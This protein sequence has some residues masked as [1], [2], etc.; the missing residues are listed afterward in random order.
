[1]SLLLLLSGSPND[2]ITEP[3]SP[4]T[5]AGGASSVTSFTVTSPGTVLTDDVVLVMVA[6]RQDRTIT[7]PSGWSVVSHS[8]GSGSSGLNLYAFW[9]R[10]NPST[11]T[12]SLSVTSTGWAYGCRVFRG[13]RTTGTPWDTTG[14]GTGSDT[15]VETPALSSLA[16]N[17]LAVTFGG[18]AD[19]SAPLPTTFGSAPAGWSTTSEVENNASQYGMFSSVQQLGTA[20]SV[21]SATWTLDATPQSWASRTIAFVDAVSPA[22]TASG[23]TTTDGTATLAAIRPISASGSTTTD[24]AAAIDLVV[25]GATLSITASGATTTDG[26]AALVAIRPVS[27]NGTTTTDGAAALGVT[28]P[29][30]GSG[31]TTTN[32]AAAIDLVPGGT[33]PITASGATTT[34]GAA[35]ITAIRP[36]VAS[37]T[38]TTDGAVALVVIRPISA[39]GSTTT[40]GT[41][42]PNATR[43]V[44]AAGTTTTD[45]S[46][47]LT[48]VGSV[49]VVLSLTASSK[50]GTDGTATLTRIAVITAAG[51]TTLDGQAII[52]APLPLTAVGVTSC[53]GYA[54]IHIPRNGRGE[55]RP[56]GP[57]MRS[58]RL[59]RRYFNP[60]K[61]PIR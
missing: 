31:A 27:A 11:F 15:T 37:G 41:A 7:T 17:C 8:Q 53:D 3:Y 30:T 12:F 52:G 49:V 42:T 16:Q 48:I 29:V 1:M 18:Y 51:V 47:T 21:A 2:G 23:A 45:G 44:A 35:S 55:Y 39:S 36:L 54:G 33:L 10:G 19:T 24:G 58:E 61:N 4:T 25:G 59:R 50:T 40:S 43:P 32:G 56:P 14:T 57:V 28:R 46:A 6:T 9:H 22:I 5:G 38:T 34:N 60:A 13:V 26:A 20:D